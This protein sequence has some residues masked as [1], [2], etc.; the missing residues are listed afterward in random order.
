MVSGGDEE[1]PTK[2]I[3]FH[4]RS[5]K[6]WK[7][8]STVL[9]FSVVKGTLTSVSFH[10][11]MNAIWLIRPIF[12]QYIKTDCIFNF[13]VHNTLVNF[14]NA[15]TVY[16]LLSTILLFPLQS[17]AAWSIYND[18]N[19]NS[20]IFFLCVPNCCSCLRKI[21]SRTDEQKLHL[22]PSSF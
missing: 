1:E 22:L 5:T 11:H 2:G 12:N 13:P 14:F 15:Y 18:D 6:C 21:V 3:G 16:Q 4:P 20:Y 17:A 19:S 9:T 8:C 10:M 7:S